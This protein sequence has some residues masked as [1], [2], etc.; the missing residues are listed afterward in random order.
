MLSSSFV[1]SI[2][3]LTELYMAERA[4]GIYSAFNL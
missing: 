1:Y 2:V 4:R 3:S